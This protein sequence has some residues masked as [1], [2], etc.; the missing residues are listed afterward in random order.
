MAISI[1]FTY[2]SAA[3]LDLQ[4]WSPLLCMHGI[5][6]GIKNSMPINEVTVKQDPVNRSED[7]FPPSVSHSVIAH[8][9]II[10]YLDLKRSFKT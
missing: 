1:L 8:K 10:A 2:Y 6:V 7:T 4:G 9:Y 5:C 3:F